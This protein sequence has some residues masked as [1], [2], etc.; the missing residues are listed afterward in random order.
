VN[1]VTK[2]VCAKGV[3]YELSNERSNT[4][5]TAFRAMQLSSAFINLVHRHLVGLTGQV[6][7]L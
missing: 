6:V 7:S 4:Q 3:V 5:L 2:K 1:N